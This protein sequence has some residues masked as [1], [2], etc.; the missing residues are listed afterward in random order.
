MRLTQHQIAVFKELSTEIFGTQA[1]LYL[2]G[3]RVDE[4]KA[5]GDIDLYITGFNGELKDQIDAKIR[6]LA[7]AKLSIGEQRID[8]VFAPQPGTN[9]API[10]HMAEQTGVLL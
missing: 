7:K 6:F 2:F 9:H 5:G 10:H 1:Q 4:Q 3:S 8:I